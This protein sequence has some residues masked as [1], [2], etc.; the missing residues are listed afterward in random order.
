MKKNNLVNCNIEIKYTKMCRLFVKK[1]F[2]NKLPYELILEIIK[3]I[4]YNCI[5]L[6]KTNLDF[7]IK[8]TN[9]MYWYK[10]SNKNKQDQ[11][12]QT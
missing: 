7:E 3:Y 2:K 9:N 10:K 6:N 4:S 1:S 8:I 5:K 12:L 11:Q